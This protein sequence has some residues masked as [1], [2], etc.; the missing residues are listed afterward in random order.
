MITSLQ[1]SYLTTGSYVQGSRTVSNQGVLSLAV[2]GASVAGTALSASL[3]STLF[4]ATANP[5][6]LMSLGSGVGSAVMGAGGIVAQAAFIPVA[7]SIPVVAPILA[8]QAISTA[9]V[10]N[11]F[12]KV[13]RK[14]DVIK[15]GLDEAIARA[16]A[17]Y[18]GELITASETID[19]IYLQYETSGAFSNDMLI[20]LALAERDIS[21]LAERFKLLLDTHEIT[22]VDDITDVQRANY[23]AHSAMLTSFLDLRVTHLRVSVDMQENPKALAQSVARLKAKIASGAALWQHLLHR[24]EAFRDAIKDREELLNDMNWAQRF[25]PEFAGGGGAAAERRLSALKDAYLAT[26]QSE[27]GIMEGFDSL[28]QAAK[29]TLELLDNPNVGLDSSPTLVYWRDDS[30]EHSFHADSLRIA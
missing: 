26:L 23:D 22:E 7:S 20:R 12:K 21:R 1:S 28:I 11:Q 4:M 14:L 19:D 9:I 5:A 3:S 6:T 27:L 18:A 24:S 25:L 15:H 8:I 13:N 17:T 29:E 30:G 16:E 10:L 2:A